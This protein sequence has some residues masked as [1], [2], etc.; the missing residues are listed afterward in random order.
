VE[1]VTWTRD[2]ELARVRTVAK[3]KGRRDDSSVGND[4][5]E[6]TVRSV[7]GKG[8][9]PAPRHLAAA[10]FFVAEARSQR[11]SRSGGNTNVPRGN[12]CPAVRRSNNI[13]RS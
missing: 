9:R 13:G 7:S 11:E 1:E 5:G 6:E 2:L 8:I 10:T 4:V 12:A 3:G